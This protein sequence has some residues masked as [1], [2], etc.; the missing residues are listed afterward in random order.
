MHAL[1]VLNIDIMYYFSYNIIYNDT[2]IILYLP[3]ED[4][5][6]NFTGINSNNF[7]YTD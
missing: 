3:F 1:F 2:I 4:D 5:F 7:Y 6:T